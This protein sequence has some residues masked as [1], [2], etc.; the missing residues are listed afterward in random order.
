MISSFSQNIL[1][2]KKKKEKKTSDEFALISN[3]YI[4]NNLIQ[5]I[6]L[7]FPFSSKHL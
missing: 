5:F 1:L 2:L 3:K 6:E 4:V 7:S